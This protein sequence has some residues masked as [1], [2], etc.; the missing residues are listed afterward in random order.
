[1]QGRDRFLLTMN[2]ERGTSSARGGNMKKH[3]LI[4][5][6]LMVALTVG[7]NSWGKAAPKGTIRNE[8][9]EA[10]VRKNLLEDRITGLEVDVYEDGTAYLKGHVKNRSDRDKAREDALKV[11]GVKRV[12]NNITIE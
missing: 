3:L 12:V 4:P 9:V 1:M 2:V 11:Y 7:C 8:V 6:V 5:M 10:D